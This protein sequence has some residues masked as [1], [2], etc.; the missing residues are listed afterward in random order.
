ML[1][2]TVRKQT[3]PVN[4]GRRQRATRHAVQR[5]LCGDCGRPLAITR[6]GR[7]IPCRCWQEPG[8]ERVAQEPVVFPAPP[9]SGASVSVS[10]PASTYSFEQGPG[11]TIVVTGGT[12]PYTVILD[13]QGLLCDCEAFKYSRRRPR[14]CKHI[15]LATEWQRRSCPAPSAA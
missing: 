10:A 11:R 15:E 6:R 3:Q 9:E 14:S 1:G 12:R 5:D 8:R 13:A 7:L 2:Q 4:P